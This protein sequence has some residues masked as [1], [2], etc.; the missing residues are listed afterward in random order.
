[1]A[2]P[3]RIRILLGWAG[4][5]AVLGVSSWFGWQSLRDAKPAEGAGAGPGR[6]PSVVIVRPAVEKEVVESLTVTGTLRAVRRAEVAALEAAAVDELAVD[7]GDLVEEGGLLARL[8]QRRLESQ[9]QEAEAALTSAQAELAQ[10]KA[11]L[12]RALQNQEMMRDLWEE[13]AVAERE[14]LDSVREFKVAEAR[15][16]VSEKSI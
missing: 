5:A 15:G 11:E 14:Y 1:M 12:D 10:R 2:S 13:R 6:P 8:D 9:L 16:Q 4:L 3:N 7:E